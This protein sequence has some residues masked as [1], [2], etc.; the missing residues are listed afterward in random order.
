MWTRIYLGV[1]A[2]AVLA[3]GFFNYYSWSWLQSIGRPEDAIAGYQRVS[4]MGWGML[5]F[6]AIVLV[7]V[8]CGTLWTTHR[9]WALWLTFA[10]FAVFVLLEG[11]VL[12]RGYQQLIERT[13]GIETKVWATPVIS[14]LIVVGSAVLTLAFQYLIFLIRAKFEPL[15]VQSDSGPEN[16]SSRLM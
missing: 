8:A 7:F 14:V 13:T 6:T 2:A 16:G 4:A 3:V 11:F 10:F 15:D 12:D 9:A 5:C 1:F